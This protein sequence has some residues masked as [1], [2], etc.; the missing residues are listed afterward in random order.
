MEERV[1]EIVSGTN[2]YCVCVVTMFQTTNKLPEN[3]HLIIQNIKKY[4]LM[5]NYAQAKENC[6]GIYG[7]VFFFK[8]LVIGQNTY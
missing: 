6:P 1:Q 8:H 4:V 7:C 2:Q 3:Y 5:Q